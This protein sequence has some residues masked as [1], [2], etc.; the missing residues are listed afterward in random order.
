MKRSLS[1]PIVFFSLTLLTAMSAAQA[2]TLNCSKIKAEIDKTIKSI[3]LN[4]KDKKDVEDELNIYFSLVDS[5][6]RCPVVTQKKIT[7]ISDNE[8]A[9]Y[10]VSIHAPDRSYELPEE[11]CT[12]V[13]VST[14]K[15]P[16]NS[17]QN[18]LGWCFAWTAAD[19]ISFHEDV[20]VSAYDIALQYHNSDETK[21][22]SASFY[23]PDVKV[24]DR[25]GFTLDAVRI[26][27]GPKGICTE[28]STNLMHEQWDLNSSLI[29]MLIDSEKSLHENLC[30]FHIYARNL[31]S[32]INPDIVKILDKL[33]ND[34]K[35][36]ALLDIGC[37]ERHIVKNEYRL[38]NLYLDRP[39]VTKDKIIDRLDKVLSKNEPVTIGYDS[40]LLYSG[41]NY[42]GKNTDHAST[43][44][45]RKFNRAT[46]QCEYLIKNSWGSADDCQKTSSIRCE[47]GNYWVSRT[48]LRNNATEV[49]WMEKKPAP[50]PKVEI[51]K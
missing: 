46:G 32:G 44:I 18:N 49:T 45:G 40:Q 12:E 5:L 34:K 17:N 50:K 1:L 22:S 47:K 38:L 11:S 13:K 16:K 42:I 4:Y 20:K 41:Q 26:A 30:S 36:A 28:E 35:W 2:E 51:Q 23:K 24:T 10:R 31:F 43:I 15:M 27:S 48:S 14:D 3:R 7:L 37:R 25:G 33:P 9:K 19:L 39:G 29:Q 21:E 6:K 8:I